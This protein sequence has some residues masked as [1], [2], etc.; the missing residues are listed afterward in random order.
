MSRTGRASKHI[1]GSPACWILWGVGALSIT[2]FTAC[3]TRV[4][5]VLT[6]QLIP[7]AFNGHTMPPDRIWPQP[8]W[9]TD[10]GSME[11]SEL[12]AR[13][14]A[15]NR[16][17]AVAAARVLAA[18]ARRAVEQSVL[19]PQVTAQA[20]ATRSSPSSVQ[21]GHS[22]GPAA[23]NAF[24]MSA[25]A[26]Y[27]LDVWGQQLASVRAAS[28]Q[29]KSAHFAQ[30]A[31]A[32]TLT[33]NVANTYFTLLTLRQR[34]AIA[35]EDVTAINGLLDV[36][37]LRVATGSASHLDLAR[38]QAQIEAVKAQL[39][40][41][42]ERELET[43]VALAVLLGKVPESFAVNEATAAEIRIPEVGPGLPSDLL[44]RRPDVAQAEANLAAA[45]ANLDAARA[46]FLPQFSLTGDAG[47]AS[48]TAGALFRGPNFIWDAGAGL[49]QTLFDGGKLLGQKRL[50]AA[51]QQELVAAYQSSVLNAYADVETALGQVT[52]NRIAEDHLQREISAAREAFDIAQLQYRQGA[53]DL[54][55]VLQAQQTL[56]D[57]RDQLAQI[58]LARLQSA[59]HLYEALGGG[60]IE[61]AGDRTQFLTQ[62]L[63]Q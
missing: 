10:F 42:Q 55:I 49:L 36:I 63:E 23:E 59:V 22:Q 24:K 21:A 60:W 29:L 44:S 20:Q 8:Q 61:S 5:Q 38:E 57:A 14:E 47:Y 50:A 56:F 11:L 16:D 25:A 19:F 53:A 35:N 1:G 2:T 6:P 3:A 37:K 7:P 54:L 13:A 33:A 27:E 41:L 39:P 43:R 4:P 34:T 31:V 51:T 12:I 28:E 62:S 17:L 15:D 52:G 26:S 58:R 18:Q 9:W 40:L 32:L 30:R 45:H 46:A 48:T